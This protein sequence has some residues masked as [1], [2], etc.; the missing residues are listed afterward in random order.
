MPVKRWKEKENF[1]PMNSRPACGGYPGEESR[2]RQEKN[3]IPDLVSSH[4]IKETESEGKRKE[5]G[6]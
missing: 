3:M 5:V 6:I 4:E 1:N 2:Y